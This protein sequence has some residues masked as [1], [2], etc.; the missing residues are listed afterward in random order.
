M[1]YRKPARSDWTKTAIY[2]ALYISVIS[3]GALLLL[4]RGN[5]GAL[6]WAVIV[7]GG[8]LLQVR[9]DSRMTAYLLLD[10]VQI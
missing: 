1:A 7:V 3:A 2:L 9:W 6:L 8:L 4:P 10:F 5:V